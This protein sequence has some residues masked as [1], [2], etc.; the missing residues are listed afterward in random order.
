MENTN[1]FESF[2]I[3]LHGFWGFVSLHFVYCVIQI[4]I[5]SIRSSDWVRGFAQTVKLQKWYT[6]YIDT[7]FNKTHG[8]FESEHN[9]WEYIFGLNRITFKSE[10]VS[11]KGHTVQTVSVINHNIVQRFLYSWMYMTHLCLLVCGLSYIRTKTWKF[12]RSTYPLTNKRLLHSI[13]WHGLNILHKE[14]STEGPF[15]LFV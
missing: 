11:Q 1:G 2:D 8:V 13:A 6:L 14:R 4:Y 10:Y 3:F 7:E 15:L 12:R 9:T 5:D